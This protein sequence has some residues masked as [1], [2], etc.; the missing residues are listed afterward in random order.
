MVYL[1]IVGLLNLILVHLN[2]QFMLAT[3][4]SQ[5]LRQL[6][7]IVLLV[8][9]VQFNHTRFMASFCLPQLLLEKYNIKL[10]YTFK[11]C[12]LK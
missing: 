2:L 12:L 8:T 10:I 6:A 4:L 9:V 7:L 3:H 5:S 11:Y 1:S